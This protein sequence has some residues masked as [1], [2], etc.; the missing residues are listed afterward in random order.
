MLAAC[1]SSV[2]GFGRYNTR[3][4]MQVRVN[5]AGKVEYVRNGLIIYTSKRNPTYPLAVDS[6]FY[7]EGAAITNVT[8]SLLHAMRIQVI[9]IR[10]R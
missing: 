6:S 1:R 7:S 2:G 4:K 3:D 8:H 5:A 10:K 9:I